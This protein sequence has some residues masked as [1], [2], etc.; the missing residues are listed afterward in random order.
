MNFT[1]FKYDVSADLY[2]YHGSV[3]FKLLVKELII[4]TCYKYTFWMR[5]A[6]FLKEKGLL[7]KPLYIF[8]KLMLRKYMFKFGIQIHETTNIGSGLYIGHFGTIVIHPQAVIGRDCNIAQGVTIGISN[9][10]K[11]IGVPVI[12]DR[13]FLGAGAKVIGGIRIGNDVL[14]APNAV[15]TTDVPDKAVVV[16]IPAKIAS[17]QGVDRYIGNYDYDN[18]LSPQ[19]NKQ[20]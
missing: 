6:R 11:N 19:N 2:R 10:G 20:I 9:R 17:Y 14:I 3:K 5:T 8:A 18:V 1:K 13:V 7:Y 15:V 16:G 4:G 12:G